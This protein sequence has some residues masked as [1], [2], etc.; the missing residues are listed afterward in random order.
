M[1]SETVVFTHFALILLSAVITSALTLTAAWYVYEKHLKERLL[2]QL[3]EKTET[4]GLELKERVREGVREG[5]Q[6][7]FTGLPSD[8]VGKATKSV[9][10]TGLG[11][12]EDSMNLW[13][14]PSKKRK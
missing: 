1:H 6:E 4:L 10:K 13:F 11:V 12:F 8:I 2:R 5:I 3:E 7:G 9:T 14:G